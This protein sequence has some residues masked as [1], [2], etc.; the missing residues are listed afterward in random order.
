[1]GSSK[2][3][4]VGYKY[5]CGVHMVLCHGPIDKITRIQIADKEAWKGDEPGSR[6]GYTVIPIRAPYLFGGD[7]QEGGVIGDVDVGMGYPEQPRN[8]YLLKKI[9]N[10]LMPAYRGV[11][12]L[13]L[14]GLYL[15]NNPYLKAWKV[16]A[17]RIHTR[18][19]GDPQW[20][21]DLAEIITPDVDGADMNPI[22]IIR[23]CLTNPVWGRGLPES[24]V[25]PSFE[26]AA[27]QLYAEGLGLS[28]MWSDEAPIEDFIN[29][30]M[31]HIDAARYEDPVTG[32]QEIKL[33]RNDY[34]VNQTPRLNE[35]NS[36]L[37]QLIEPTASEVANQITVKYW[38]R[39]T[40]EDTSLCVQ[41]TAAITMTGNIVS[42]TMEYPGITND[43]VALMVAQ[44]DL[45]QFSRPFAKGRIRT[46][47]TV[48][49]LRP[50][51]V[52]RLED[53]ASGVSSM[54]CR[55]AKR[56][57]SGLLDG[58]VIYEF[59]EDVFGQVY[60]TVAPPSPPGWLRPDSSAV[61]FGSATA[62]EVP[63]ALLVQEFGTGI[64]DTLR[65]ESGYFGF[66]GTRPGAGVHVNYSLWAY[67]KDLGPVTDTRKAETENFTPFAVVKT[68]TD[69]YVDTITVS[70]IDDANYVEKG[71]LVLV[72]NA[73]DTEREIIALNTDDFHGNAAGLVLPILR[74][75]ADTLPRPIPPGTV[76]YCIDAFVGSYSQEWVQGELVQGHGAPKTGSS[77]YAGPFSYREVEMRGRGFRPYPP[78]N[79][80]IDGRSFGS[81]AY[82]ASAPVI[83]WR[84]RNR[85]VQ[86]EKAINWYEDVDYT[87]EQGTTYRIEADAYGQPNS[88]G[89]LGPLIAEKWLVRDIGAVGTFTLDILADA[90]PEGTFG[91]MVRVVAVRDGVDCLQVPRTGFS[92]PQP[93]IN[94]TLEAVNG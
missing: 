49:D 71:Q 37:E 87:P 29:E 48:A 46:N 25:G 34:D 93:P 3:Q 11:A 44:R 55:V 84:H 39:V 2:K 80:K 51:D 38:N 28:L 30:V 7:G 32:L 18:H 23:E 56:S 91:V 83:T 82:Q 8:G 22:H 69:E 74:G 53:S 4:T 43:H 5:Y 42:Q 90:P 62:F 31:R 16:T 41:D 75:V 10:A 63:Y 20:R 17:Q 64:A 73:I 35:F 70:E 72:G 36:D 33:I 21:D 12:S 65:P 76:L 94:L 50:G 26:Q 77:V 1:M 40:G 66:A 45:A 61:D 78:A 14:K 60:N 9:G 67:P 89:N 86:A 19:N 59:G 15:G 88:P 58:N 52:F 13:V 54:V 24:E 27:Q 47:R 79:L 68:G 85:V 57:E 6:T 81:F 92:I